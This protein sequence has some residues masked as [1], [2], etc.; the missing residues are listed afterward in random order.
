MQHFVRV[1]KLTN[2]LFYL[3]I[4]FRDKVPKNANPSVLYILLLLLFKK[5]YNILINFL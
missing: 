3:V 4:K 1:N 2:G 5:K